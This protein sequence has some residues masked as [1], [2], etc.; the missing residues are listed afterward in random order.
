MSYRSDYDATVFV[1]E[2]VAAVIHTLFEA[3]ALVVLVVI[4]F[5]QTWRDGRP[6]LGSHEWRRLTLPILRVAVGN[7]KKP[8]E[9]GFVNIYRL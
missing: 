3:I 1:R 6:R 4:L 2:S 7:K 5:L 9:R 8:R